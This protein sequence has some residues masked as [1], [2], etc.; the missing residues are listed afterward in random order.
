MSKKSDAIVRVEIVPST[1]LFK[2][3]EAAEALK[4]FVQAEFARCMAN[5]EDL[6]FQ[7]FFQAKK[8]SDEIR[9]MQTIPEQRKWALYFKKWGCLV[10]RSQQAPHSSCGMCGDCHARTVGRLRGITERYR[11]KSEKHEDFPVVDHGELAHQA[12]AGREAGDRVRGAVP[13]RV[14]EPSLVDRQ[15]RRQQ[16]EASGPGRQESTRIARQTALALASPR[17]RLPA[18]DSHAIES[19]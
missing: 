16:R 18:A 4:N 17:R 12:L 11:R 8:V 2:S 19:Q 1:P 13:A 3:R 15:H 6:V 7:P 10:C 5:R 9:R 14:H